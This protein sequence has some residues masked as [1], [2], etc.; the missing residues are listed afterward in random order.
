MESLATLLP[1]NATIFVVILANF[2]LAC[3][4]LT[5]AKY[6]HAAITH[7][8]AD[9]ELAIRDN[10][11]FGVSMAG[12][13]LGVMIMMTGVMSSEASLD[14]ELQTMMTAGYGALGVILLS[15]SRLIFDK[16]S[17]PKFHL[18]NEI[19]KGNMAAAIVDFSNVV[20]SALVVRAVMFWV[21]SYSWEGLGMVVLTFAISQVLMS[22]AAI[23]RIKIY[24]M[25]Y[26]SS[27]QAQLADGNAASAWQFGG[28]R[29]GMALAITA[30]SELIPYAY[31]EFMLPLVSWLL[32]SI[33]MIIVVKLVA[34]ATTM[35]LLSG[36]DFHQEVDKEQNTAIGILQGVIYISVGLLVASLV[37]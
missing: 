9:D 12:V 32:A 10:P 8:K 5:C 2:A 3:I 7:V 13:V 31:E 26:G 28:Y 18:N 17:L 27:M 35:V 36:I 29:I 1:M 11:A 22:I 14:L 15:L 6:L 23:G 33:V 21:N 19:L 4:V 20:A 34:A 30:A 37:F 25:R 24:K 16:I